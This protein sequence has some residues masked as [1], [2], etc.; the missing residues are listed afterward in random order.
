MHI[1]SICR[2]WCIYTRERPTAERSEIQITGN[3][4]THNSYVDWEKWDT[5]EQMDFCIFPFIQKPGKWV[6]AAWEQ[7]G[8]FKQE[9]A[10]TAGTQEVLF[11][12]GGAGDM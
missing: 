11:L 6:L 8:L 5:K 7:E 10:W 3:N 12:D 1:E 4:E 9:A 2:L